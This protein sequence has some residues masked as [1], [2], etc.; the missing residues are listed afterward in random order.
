MNRERRSIEAEIQD[1]A[2]SQLDEVDPRD[3]TT[4]SVFDESWHHG[5]IGIVASRLKDKFYRPTITFAPSEE[6]KLRGSGRSI[7]G[8]HLRDALD[9]VSKQAPSLIEKFGGHAMAAGLTIRAEA[10]EAFSEAFETVGREW[11]STSQ[12]ERILETDGPLE[13]QYYT[14]EFCELLSEQVWGQG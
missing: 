4:I 1:S 13:E 5:V 3:K 9:L 2:L 6:G 10:F 11:L 12:L 7:S 8:F 14:V